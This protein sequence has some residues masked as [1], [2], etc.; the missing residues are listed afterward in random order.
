MEMNS[1]CA[2]LSC[3]ALSQRKDAN[4][5]AVNRPLRRSRMCLIDAAAALE[6]G[7]DG[8]ERPL[9]ID[10]DV[11]VEEPRIVEDRAGLVQIIQQHSRLGN[12]ARLIAQFA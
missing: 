12:A 4:S 10:D 7:I 2:A 3:P 9:L 8:I 6:N 11:A 5:D 1:A